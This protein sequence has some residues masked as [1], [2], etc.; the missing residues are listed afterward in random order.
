MMRFNQSW[1]LDPNYYGAYWGF[2]TLMLDK[3]NPKKAIDYFDK[4]ISLIE[5]EDKAKSGLLTESARAYAWEALN[6]DTKNPEESK[7]LHKKANDMID[8]ALYLDSKN[9]K[10][11]RMGGIIAKAQGNY[12]RAWDIVKRARKSGAFKFNDKFIAELTEKLPE[13]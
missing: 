7:I 11:Y 2:G 12:K 8:T 10:A 4:A 1:L 6:L 13:P 9:G 3:N 5:D